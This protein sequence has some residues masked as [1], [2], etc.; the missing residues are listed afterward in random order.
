MNRIETALEVAHL[1]QPEFANRIIPV[2]GDLAQPLLGMSASLFEQ[3]ATTVDVIYHNASLVSS[4]LPYEELKATNVLGTID[5]L[6]L[7]TQRKVKPLH[8]ISTLSVFSPAGITP[9]QPVLEEAALDTHR[10]YLLE[11]YEQSKWVAEKLVTLAR[12][13]GLPVAI[14]RPG[15][16]TGHSRTGAWQTNVLLCRQIKGCIQLGSIPAIIASDV[17]EMI[18]VDYISQSIVAL[19][20]RS[21]S[22]GQVF[23]LWNATCVSVGEIVAWIND[24]GYPVQ[25]VPYDIWHTELQRTMEQNSTN[26]LTPFLTIYPEQVQ[27][28]VSQEST[29]RVIFDDRNTRAALAATSIVCPPVNARLL[30]TYLSYL[31][32]CG[33]LPPPHT[34]LHR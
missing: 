11:G 5:V 3:L 6:R 14:Y 32:R 9:G 31:V 28:H 15:R 22:L 30:H 2:P 21:S 29:A 25:Q 23:H 7:A 27:E 34:L 10:D 16:M 17:L 20:T 19:S 24:F 13:R 4:V 1:W 26:T 18:P 33:F 8:Y 12:E